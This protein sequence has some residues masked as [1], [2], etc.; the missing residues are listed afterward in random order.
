M[1]KV[2]AIIRPSLLGAVREGLAKYGVKGLTVTEALGCGH[3]KPQ[4]SVY[5]G[6]EYSVSLLRK[7]KLEVVVPADIVDEV[8]DIIIERG[9]TGEV[10]DGKVFVLPVAEAYCIRTGE[11]GKNAL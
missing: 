10:G 6:Q 9:R 3:E 4:V 5:R 2:E 1:R 11:S 8:V 7:V